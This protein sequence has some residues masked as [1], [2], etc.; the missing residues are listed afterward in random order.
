MQHVCSSRQ[1]LLRLSQSLTAMT[2]AII[3]TAADVTA[4][5]VASGGGG[6]RRCE[7]LRFELE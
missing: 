1:T 7:E 5:G 2:A 3:L 4:F 6:R